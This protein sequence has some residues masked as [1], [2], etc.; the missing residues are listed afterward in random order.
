MAFPCKDLQGLRLFSTSPLPYANLR[1]S[2]ETQRTGGQ[3]EQEAP[4]ESCCCATQ[5]LALARRPDSEGMKK[6]NGAGNTHTHMYIHLQAKLGQQPPLRP[7]DTGEDGRAW[8]LKVESMLIQ[9]LLI[10]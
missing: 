6:V 10:R 7:Y 8:P 4:D 5:R 1:V 3:Q 9:V 2:L